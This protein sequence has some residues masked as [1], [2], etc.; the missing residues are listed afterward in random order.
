MSSLLYRIGRFA[1]SRPWVAIGAWVVVAVAVVVASA[2]GGRDLQDSMKVPG[3]DSQ[4]AV[5]L[6]SAAKSA[7]ANGLALGAGRSCGIVPSGK[8]SAASI[9]PSLRRHRASRF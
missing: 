2:T 7:D 6:L 9:G 4:K 3:L 8:N 5:D 1:A